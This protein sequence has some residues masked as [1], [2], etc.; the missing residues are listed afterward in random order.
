MTRVLVADKLHPSTVARLNERAGLELVN[1]PELTT[2][3]LCDHLGGVD[4]LVVR[5]TKVTA[6]ALRAADALGVVIRAG[7]GVNTIDVA[8]AS[9]RGVYVANCPGRNA[10]AVAELAMGLI[11]AADR[12]IADNVAEMRQGRWNKKAFSK[13]R[14]I[15]GRTLGVIGTGSIGRELIARA[16][17]F[18]VHVLA[19]SRSLTPRRASDLGAECATDLLDLARRSDIVSLHLALAGETRGLLGREF[20]EALRPGTIFVNTSRAEV[21]DGDAMRDALRPGRIFAG[22]DVYDNE[23]SG[24]EAEFTNDL[25]LFENVYGTHHV[26]A[27][28]DQ[29]EQAIG[30]EV[31]HIID[32][33]VAGGEIPNCVNLRRPGASPGGVVVRHEDRVGVLAAVLGVLREAGCN[34]QEM[35]NQIFDAPGAAACARIMLSEAPSP[36]LV[37]RIA[38]S[39]DGVIHVTPV[40]ANS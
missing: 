17:P 4:V 10:A 23:P 24:G 28:T 13:A 35:E 33:F 12:R 9:R 20:F 26:G 1:K 36:A 39:C 19:W 31:V 27:S 2:E 22:L 30:E 18:G 38:K 40:A 7:A 25:R 8:E 5:S 29:A 11:L 37:E 34:V 32:A 21:V 16:I 6:D 15:K 14:G 3:T